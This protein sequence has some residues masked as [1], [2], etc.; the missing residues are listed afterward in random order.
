MPRKRRVCGYGG[1]CLRRPGHT[2]AHTASAAAGTHDWDRDRDHEVQADTTLRAL[3]FP[4]PEWA[5]LLDEDES[6]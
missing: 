1:F 4:T 6:A 5:D 3:D 2:G